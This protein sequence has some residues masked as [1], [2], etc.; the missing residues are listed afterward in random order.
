MTTRKRGQ[1]HVRDDRKRARVVGKLE[2]NPAIVRAAVVAI[3]GVLASLGVGWAADVDEE[4]ITSLSVAIPVVALLVG[5]LIR[6]VVTPVVKVVSR[7]TTDGLVVAGGAAEIPEGEVLATMRD[8]DR[9]VTLPVP[10]DPKRS[11]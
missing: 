11:T 3:L 2:G 9:W 8:G 7:V 4:T 6:Q 10:V 5:W 1:V